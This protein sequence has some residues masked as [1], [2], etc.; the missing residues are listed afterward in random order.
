MSPIRESPKRVSGRTFGRKLGRIFG[1]NCFGKKYGFQWWKITENVDW[2]WFS[3]QSNMCQWVKDLVTETQHFYRNSFG[4][5]FGQVSARIFGPKPVSVTHWRWQV[6][7][8]CFVQIF[9]MDLVW[10]TQ[11]MCSYL[12]V[13]V[14]AK[15][16]EGVVGTAVA[17]HLG[18]LLVLLLHVL[19][20]HRPGDRLG[21][22]QDVYLILICFLRTSF[23]KL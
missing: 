13:L 19:G 6:K 21:W 23:K 5:I 1:R 16:V 12:E 4:R 9:A 11:N 7:M 22:G 14:Q 20:Q 18:R 15:W 8:R 2:H 3:R 17:H 10:V